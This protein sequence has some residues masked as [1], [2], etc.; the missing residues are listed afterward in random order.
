[1][2]NVHLEWSREKFDA[3]NRARKPVGGVVAV[4]VSDEL[5]EEYGTLA[6]GASSESIAST[7]P[8]SVGIY[9]VMPSS[10]PEEVAS[11]V[12]SL[13]EIKEVS[14]PPYTIE[15]E[16]V[17]FHKADPDHLLADMRNSAWENLAEQNPVEIV[18][19]WGTA[20]TA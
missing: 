8:P 14:V 15:R 16:G 11:H 18:E 10:D 13:W 1:M 4:L 3:M 5:G 17:S 9:A 2:R 20:A 7:L 19:L 6:T 12:M